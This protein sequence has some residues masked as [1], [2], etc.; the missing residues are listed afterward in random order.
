MAVFS[1]DQLIARGITSTD[2][3]GEKDG[4]SILDVQTDPSFT[5][6]IRVERSWSRLG[7]QN[8]DK[9]DLKR[10]CARP[11]DWDWGPLIDNAVRSEIE[12]RQPR[13]LARRTETQFLGKQFCDYAALCIKVSRVRGGCRS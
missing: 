7:H 1:G 2:M 11:L 4:I 8:R 13:V 6:H 5:T 9:G 3:C 10:L 12:W